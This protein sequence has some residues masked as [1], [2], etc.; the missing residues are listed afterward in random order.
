[1]SDTTPELTPEQEQAIAD[2]GKMVSDI[3]AKIARV[4][5][6]LE[7]GVQ[8]LNCGL[9]RA[10]DEG[11]QA[12]AGGIKSAIRL[13]ASLEKAIEIWPGK[14]TEEMENLLAGSKENQKKFRKMLDVMGYKEEDVGRE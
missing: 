6:V 1:M 9:I 12:V 3:V 13:N 4:N 10:K 5:N 8:A 7:I 14:R 2:Y 11:G